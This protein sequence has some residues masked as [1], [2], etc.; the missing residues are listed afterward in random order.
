[1]RTREVA[2]VLEAQQRAK[3]AD[4]RAAGMARDLA[5]L[6]RQLEESQSSE[7]RLLL[8]VGR[9]KERLAEL[10][11][12]VHL[13]PASVLPPVDTPLIIRI[14]DGRIVK[15]MRP[16]FLTNR[17]DLILYRFEDGSEVEGR[18]PWSYP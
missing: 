18:F 5:E 14:P 13:N 2:R 7:M 15:A 12:D 8:K 17:N 1:M 6:R 10:E 11:V 4:R 16:I 3:D 9:L